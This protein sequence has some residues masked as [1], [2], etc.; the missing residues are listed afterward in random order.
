MNSINKC[1]LVLSFPSV[2][3][4]WFS[5]ISYSQPSVSTDQK[6]DLSKLK[7]GHPRLLL[8]PGEEKKIVAQIKKYPEWQNVHEAILA[9]C[10]RIDTMPP[11]ERIKIGKRLLGKSRECLRRVFQLSYAYRTTRD[12]KFL[13]RAENEMLAVA[14][15][16]DWNPS[17]FLD[18]A[19]MTLAVA[20]GYD[21]LY[22][23]LSPTSRAVIR[24]AIIEKGIEPSFDSRYNGFVRSDNNWNQVCN[25]GMTFGA[26]AVA[27]YEPKLAQSVIERA[28]GS[29]PGV[30]KLSYS[31]DG[32]YPEGYSYWDYGTGFNVMLIDALQKALGTDYGLTSIPGFLKTPDFIQNI[33]GPIGLVHNWSDSGE[34]ASIST[35]SFWF[36]AR[37]KDPSLLYGQTKYFAKEN[38]KRLV[39]DRLL[40]T[41]MLWGTNLDLSKIKTPKR[42][43]WV[44]QGLNPVGFMRTS[45]S[46]PN[47]IFVG[48]KAGSGSVNHGH[49]DVG[50]FVLDANGERWAMDF[51]N[52]DY[53]SLESKGIKLFGRSQDAQRW[54]IFRNN[55]FVHNTLTIDGQLQQVK[56]HATIDSWS[57]QADQMAL[58]SDITPSY[59]GQLKEAKRGI[60]IVNNQYTVVR[61]EIAAPEKQIVLRWTLLTAAHV[62]IKDAKTVEL[63]QHGK[64]MSLIFDASVPFE[65]KT[66]S[67]D[68]GTDYDAPNP[69]T[70]LV[71]FEASIPA[72]TSHY[73]N[74][75][76]TDSDAVLKPVEKLVNWP[77]SGRPAGGPAGN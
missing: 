46:D 51:R 60:A 70:Y 37:S 30:M 42:R 73:F 25:A 32:V 50:S 35:P 23:D 68:P 38:T 75:F 59:V 33:V 22:N 77:G 44:G 61:D 45:W 16:E 1:S 6:V 53:N 41:I 62:R 20:I 36:A 64:T 56:G 34:A 47:A 2:F 3:I 26:L 15:F 58:I 67:T 54:Q 21:W 65:I 18:V 49:M 13:K 69:G 55:N 10:A 39:G 11:V 8:L 66:W 57:E 71:G 12:P 29:V 5:C 76:F 48:F 63:T 24:K 72:G 52:Q 43:V 74:A 9:E 19:E 7:S 17:H 27:D 4:L 31:P 40:P 28:L 14:A